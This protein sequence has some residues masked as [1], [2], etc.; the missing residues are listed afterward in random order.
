M[1]ESTPIFTDDQHKAVITDIELMQYSAKTNQLAI[2]C[3]SDLAKVRHSLL[4]SSLMN[5]IHSIVN[6]DGCPTLERRQTGH[7]KLGKKSA[8]VQ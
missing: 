7:S 4:Y 8:T 1:N 5:C 2:K 3:C 6:V